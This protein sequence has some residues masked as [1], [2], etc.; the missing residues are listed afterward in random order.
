MNFDKT[1]ADG[2]EYAV[3][4]PTMNGENGNRALR[5]AAAEAGNKDM[6]GWV[7]LEDKS[8]EWRIMKDQV[9][10]GLDVD[11]AFGRFATEEAKAA[12]LAESSEFKRNQGMASD[13]TRSPR[14]QEIPL[15]DRM[16]PNTALKAEFDRDVASAK[17]N[18]VEV[19][20]DGAVSAYHVV[21]GSKEGFDKYKTPEA[22]AKW[23]SEAELSA[24]QRREMA[25]AA[26]KAID[27]TAERA[28]GRKFVADNAAGFKL[29][30]GKSS[31]EAEKS[32]NA[33]MKGLKE[34]SDVEVLRVHGRTK[35]ASAELRDKMVN[36]RLRKAL[37]LKAHEG[38]TASEFFELGRARA[39][40]KSRFEGEN[41]QRQAAGGAG[42]GPTEFGH[43]VALERGYR[44][45]RKEAI[46]RGLIADRSQARGQS[47]EQTN[48]QQG[49][50]QSRQQEGPAQQQERPAQRQEQAP[51]RE[52][53]N[54][55]AGQA[56]GDTPPAAPARSRR[57]WAQSME[58]NMGG[59]GG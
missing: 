32:N 35:E 53:E 50:Q 14:G 1:T 40:D 54:A 39:E 16:Y 34:A 46:D 18:G 41:R 11:K 43:L 22:K 28:A 25:R 48:E 56:Q 5:T 27:V 59:F 6:V 21:S 31:R 36:I 30:D 10:A 49:Q 24:G 26:D 9:P 52:L 47:N 38:F 13:L 51:A 12:S 15:E 19:K 8:A 55:G 7:R 42:L 45:I 4:Y 58:K 17:K 20:Y 44:V 33:Q 37:D 2:R 3:L 29:L 57:Q 23:E